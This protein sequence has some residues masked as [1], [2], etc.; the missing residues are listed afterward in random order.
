M[1]PV[2]AVYHNNPVP[3]A[4]NAEAVAPWQYVNGVVTVGKAGIALTVTVIA[5]LNPSQ[6]KIVCDT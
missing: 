3:V 4:L 1:P 5:A 2:G 6:P